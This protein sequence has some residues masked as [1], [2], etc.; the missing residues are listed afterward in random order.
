MHERTPSDQH[1][2]HGDHVRDPREAARRRERQEAL[3]DETIEESFPASD[4]P[5]STPVQGAG[6]PPR[7][8]HEGEIEDDTH[9]G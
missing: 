8:S 9:E 2:D 5:A 1:E 4:P 3:I 7:T 6:A